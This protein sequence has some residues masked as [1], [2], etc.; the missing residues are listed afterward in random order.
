MRYLGK[1]TGL[2]PSDKIVA[3]RV[4]MLLDQEV[5]LFTAL[6]CA[7]YTERFGFGSL[8]DEQVRTVREAIASD[9]LPR[10]LGF[11]EKM[12]STAT[13]PD[14]EGAGSG[15]LA[16]TPDATIADYVYAPRLKWLQSG[17]DNIPTNILD[18][19]PHVKKYLDQF[20]ALPKIVEYY[21]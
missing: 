18:P 11:L 15:W 8:S 20:Y 2:Y 6:S 17:L 5:D 4:D 9:V 7:T 10:H 13:G 21:S 12:L 1:L 16:N 14:G 3:A 19:F